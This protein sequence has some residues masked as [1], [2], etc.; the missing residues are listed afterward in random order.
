MRTPLRLVALAL[1][2]VIAV[3]LV[4]AVGA[5]AYLEVQA[6]RTLKATY[7]QLIQVLQAHEVALQKLTGA[8]T[9]TSTP[10]DA[11]APTAPAPP[12]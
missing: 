12:K 1:G 3:L 9:I 10:P 5:A 4:G 7:P 6:Y 8:P 2:A 11:A